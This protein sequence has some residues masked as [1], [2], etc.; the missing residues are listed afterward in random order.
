M[1][2]SCLTLLEVERVTDWLRKIPCGHRFDSVLFALFFIF[3]FLLLLG[4]QVLLW[5]RSRFHLFLKLLRLK[6]N[7]ALINHKR[8]HNPPNFQT[9]CILVIMI[10]SFLALLTQFLVFLPA[11]YSTCLLSSFELSHLCN[12]IPLLEVLFL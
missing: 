3:L 11:N 10:Y 7:R 1:T 12:T 6:L 9:F 4:C 8:H 2:S 5:S